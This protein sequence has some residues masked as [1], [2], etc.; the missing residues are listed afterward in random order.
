MT[1][2]LSKAVVTTA[3]FIKKSK[4]DHLTVVA[5]AHH[6]FAKRERVSLAQLEQAK[7]VLREHG[8]GTRK[9]FDSSIHHLIGDLD[10]WREYEH[11]PVLRSLQQTPIF[12]VFTFI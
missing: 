8:S 4:K 1:W 3:E 5:S 2:V 6:P 12:N 7:W 11:V 9:V 10:V